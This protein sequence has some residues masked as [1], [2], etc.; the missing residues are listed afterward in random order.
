[1]SRYAK[2]TTVSSEKS[3]AEIESLL[4]RYGAGQFL[5]GWDTQKAVVGFSMAGRQ[6]KFVLPLPNFDSDEF[7]F[8]PARGNERSQKQHEAAYEQA[9]KQRWRA[10]ALVIKAKLEAVESEITTFEDE[11]LSHIVMPNGLTLGESVKPQIASAYETGKMP[12][13]LGYEE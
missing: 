7:R 10:L 12:P 9:V 6:V 13:L 5:S 1:M 11:F 4:R 3:R 8:T 2:D